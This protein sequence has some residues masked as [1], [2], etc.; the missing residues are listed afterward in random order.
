MPVCTG[1]T[2]ALLK[3]QYRVEP[4]GC[5]SREQSIPP[6]QVSTAAVVEAD[7][8]SLGSMACSFFCAR[9]SIQGCRRGSILLENGL[10][11][12]YIV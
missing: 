2:A 1:A 5:S 12:K 6:G 4:S 9:Y 3:A 7:F 10:M 11:V 8:G